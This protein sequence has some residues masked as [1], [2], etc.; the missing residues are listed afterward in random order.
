MKT[1]S[2]HLK[3][4]SG[5]GRKD[6][7]DK[8]KIHFAHEFKAIIWKCTWICCLT[9]IF[10]SAILLNLRTNFQVFVIQGPLATLLW[11][12]FLGIFAEKVL[13]KV[14]IAAAGISKGFLFEYAIKKSNLS[15]FR[16]PFAMFVRAFSSF[17]LISWWLLSFCSFQENSGYRFVCQKYQ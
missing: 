8:K 2:L 17:L 16:F 6:I 1:P 9:L 4:N 13:Y 3:S 15:A 14:H 5:H 10:F 12:E 7:K 11:Q